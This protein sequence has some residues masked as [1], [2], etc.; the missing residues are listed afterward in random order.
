MQGC[1][2]CK[3]IDSTPS[4]PKL[5]EPLSWE[6]WDVIDK[7]RDEMR[8]PDTP[9][10]GSFLWAFQGLLDQDAMYRYGQKEGEE[11]K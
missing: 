4:K 2:C 9:L 8:C 3:S 5:P 10:P 11:E 1:R 7:L 6:A